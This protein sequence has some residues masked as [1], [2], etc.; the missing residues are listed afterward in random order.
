MTTYNA[1]QLVRGGGQGKRRF[2]EKK[3]FMSTG[4]ADQTNAYSPERCVGQLFVMLLLLRF[5]HGHIFRLLRLPFRQVF[6][7]TDLKFCG[8]CS[9]VFVWPKVTGLTSTSSFSRRGKLARC[10]SVFVVVVVVVVLAVVLAV[11]VVVDVVAEVVL[12]RVWQVT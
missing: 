5:W 10:G 6:F 12:Q 7:L 4:Q 1:E 8:S 11:V 3:H 2:V 9:K